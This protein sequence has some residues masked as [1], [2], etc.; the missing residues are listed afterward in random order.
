MPPRGDVIMDGVGLGALAIGSVFTYAGVK[1]FSIPQAFQYVVQ[2]K[3]PAGLPQTAGVT[4]PSEASAGGGTSPVTGGGSA[5]QILQATAA[6]FGWTGAQ[7][8]ALQQV[9]SHEAGFNPKAK[10]PSS[11]ALGL[12]QALGH[13]GTNTAGTL[14]NEYG[15][16]YGLSAEQ[17]KA[18]NSGDAAAQA[19]WMCGYIKSRYGDPVKAW[20]FW[21]SHHW[22]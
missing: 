14:G 18:A 6:R 10:N 16:N 2:G 11:G 20:A 17:A 8:Q 9:E 22:Y 12:A 3:S 4:A 5:Q 15:A 1:G 13:G 21:Q 19:L 7:W